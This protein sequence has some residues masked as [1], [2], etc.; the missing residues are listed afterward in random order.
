MYQ[1]PGNSSSAINLFSLI[2]LHTARRKTKLR[3]FSSK[4]I[5]PSPSRRVQVCKD[6]KLLVAKGCD[7]SF[8]F[9]IFHMRIIVFL[10]CPVE[11]M[12][13]TLSW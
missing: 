1:T 5:Q 11:L 4:L 3:H 9:I 13:K 8:D 12:W 6:G 2:T 10:N 7:F